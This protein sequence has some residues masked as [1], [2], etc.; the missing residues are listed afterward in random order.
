MT[1]KH[2]LRSGRCHE[3]EIKLIEIETHGT[4]VGVHEQ[5]KSGFSEVLVLLTV[6]EGV[7][8]PYAALNFQSSTS[9]PGLVD[10]NHCS[11]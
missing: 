8:A 10:R 7:R 5:L 4:E 11:S 3:R 6:P 2:L 9:F 1:D